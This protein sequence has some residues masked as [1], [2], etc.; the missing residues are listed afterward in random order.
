[1]NDEYKKLRDELAVEYKDKTYPGYHRAP[2]YYS[3]TRTDF[4][5]GFDAAYKIM[6]EREDGLIKALEFYA[7]QKNLRHNTFGGDGEAE[8]KE[9]GQ[10]ARLH[11]SIKT[12]T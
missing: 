5:A 7:Q 1:M 8:I 6:K 4:A 2:D 9:W 12:V 3:N 11:P 10:K